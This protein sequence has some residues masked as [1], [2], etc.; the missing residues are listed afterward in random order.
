MGIWRAGATICPINVEMNVAY[1]A[2]ILRGI[3]PRLTLWH[4][5]MGRGRA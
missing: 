5:A 2:P 3:E 1:I 4:E